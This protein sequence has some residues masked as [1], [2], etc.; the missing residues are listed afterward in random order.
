MA[1]DVERLLQLWTD[2][3]PDDEAAAAAFGEIY[4]DPVVINGAPVRVAGLVTRARSLR[5]AFDGLQREVLEVVDAGAT[6]TVA[7]RLRGRH[8]GP[9]TTAAG[10]VPATGR[11][12]DLRIIDVLTCTEGRISSI[13]MVADELGALVA[14]DAVRL[15]APQPDAAAER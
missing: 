1:L 11:V 15:T 4:A 10:P 8:V 2:L 13:W 7:F 5:A 14:A 6:T 12:L 9:L 3:P